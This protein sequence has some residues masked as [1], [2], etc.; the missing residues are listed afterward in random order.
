MPSVIFRACL[1]IEKMTFLL[2]SRKKTQPN[3][4]L[5]RLFDTEDGRLGAKRRR[6]R[7]VKQA[8][9]PIFYY[10]YHLSIP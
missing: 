9:I 7:F 2:A 1:K 5:T 3:R 10:P 6:F 8:I 4:R